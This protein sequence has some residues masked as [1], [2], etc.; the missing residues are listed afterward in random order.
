V[1]LPTTLKEAL[2]EWKSDDV[3]VRALGK[4]AAEK[5]VELKMQEWKEY[6]PHVPNNR[7]E[8]TPW[9]QQKYLYT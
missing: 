4:E 6:E 8:V 7:S 3:C 2:E 5:Y 1:S 9:E